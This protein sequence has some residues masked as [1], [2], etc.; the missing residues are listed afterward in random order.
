MYTFAAI[1]LPPLA[2]ERAKAKGVA[3]DAYYC[4]LLL[5]ETG[6]VRNERV[7]IWMYFGDS[8]LSAAHVYV[9]VH[10]CLRCWMW[11]VSGVRVISYPT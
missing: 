4:M 11:S 8:Y 7:V 2:V 5:E 6:V 10:V 3:P 1:T 9:D